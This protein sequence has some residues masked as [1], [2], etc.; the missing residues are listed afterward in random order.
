[1]AAVQV[2]RGEGPRRRNR[3]GD[4]VLTSRGTFQR[5]FEHDEFGRLIEETLDVGAISA[6]N[7]I[8]FV[9][10]NPV[11]SQAFLQRKNSRS[12]DFGHLRE[13]LF[14]S[15]P[16]KAPAVHHA[17]RRQS[18]Y[19]Q[20]QSLLDDYWSHMVRLGRPPGAN[21]YERFKELEELGLTQQKA[22]NLFVK[23]FGKD[24]LDEGFIEKKQ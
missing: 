13:S 9:F 23:L 24:A 2:G 20:H 21:E 10:K 6:G 16:R 22:K 11:D 19:E 8:F 14:G 12:V 15:K 5:Y 4:G 7:G 1:M 3:I 17:R 18:F